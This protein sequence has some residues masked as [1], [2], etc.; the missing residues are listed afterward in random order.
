MNREL[1]DVEAQELAR[2]WASTPN[3]QEYPPVRRISREFVRVLDYV[4]ALEAER[5]KVREAVVDF[6]AGNLQHGT[7]GLD[8]RRKALIAVVLGALGVST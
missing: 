4:Q 5:E 3:V 7:K 1:A 6:Y 2:L 8:G